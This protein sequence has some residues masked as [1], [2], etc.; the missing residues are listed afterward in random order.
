LK[1]GNPQLLEAAVACNEV[2][3]ARGRSR[4]PTTSELHLGLLGGPQ[5]IVSFL[6]P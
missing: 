6:S 3:P 1:I 5:L 2:L 4:C